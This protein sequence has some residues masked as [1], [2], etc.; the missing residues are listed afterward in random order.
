MLALKGKA[1]GAV[2]SDKIHPIIIKHIYVFACV[3][4]M[5][6]PLIPRKKG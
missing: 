3:L 6:E 2:K 4:Y 1:K 5:L